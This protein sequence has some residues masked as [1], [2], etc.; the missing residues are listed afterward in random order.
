M[1][2]L[3]FLFGLVLLAA[4]GKQVPQDK[5]EVSIK[6]YDCP[7]FCDVYPTCYE[8]RDGWF[9]SKDNVNE[10]NI[11]N[12]HKEADWKTG[13]FYDSWGKEIDGKF[14]YG[15]PTAQQEGT[16]WLD[17][18]DKNKTI[19]Y[20]IR[21]FE[22]QKLISETVCH[23][24]SPSQDLYQPDYPKYGLSLKCENEKDKQNLDVL[25]F[26]NELW[27]AAGAGYTIEMNRVSSG[28]GDVKYEE[29]YS[30]S[31]ALHNTRG[32]W[33][34]F[35]AINQGMPSQQLYTDDNRMNCEI[36]ETRDGMSGR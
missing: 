25:V 16:T 26:D 28:D 18:D 19:T 36:T 17:I 24:R 20:Q 5:E 4:C 29:K 15:S 35:N 6:I 3:I 33:V 31:Y 12:I 9:I 22:S 27:V 14:Y 34:W 2:K 13:F 23:Q 30:K 21:D 8:E 32:T 7:S 10:Y 11:R 1:K